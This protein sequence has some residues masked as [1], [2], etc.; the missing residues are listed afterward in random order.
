MPY[1]PPA[2]PPEAIADAWPRE[3]RTLT[4]P[5][6]PY[7]M[8]ELSIPKYVSRAEWTVMMDTLAVMEK[9]LVEKEAEANG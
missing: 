7:H 4:L 9:V 3:Y 8:A 6:G 5:I 2:P 1:T